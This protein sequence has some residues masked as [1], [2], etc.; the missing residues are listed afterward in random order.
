MQ[1]DEIKVIQNLL[2]QQNKYNLSIKLDGAYYKTE[3]IQEWN[4]VSSVTLEIY[5]HPNYFLD[6]ENITQDDKEIIIGV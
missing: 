2:V 1:D 4:G 3:F 5:V 6:L